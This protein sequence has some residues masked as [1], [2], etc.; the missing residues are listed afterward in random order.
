MLLVRQ[1][2]QQAE[3]AEASEAS[4]GFGRCFSEH[5]GGRGT[6]WREV[7]LRC[8]PHLGEPAPLPDSAGPSRLS[9]HLQREMT[10]RFE[11][12]HCSIYSTFVFS[13]EVIYISY[14]E[15]HEGQRSFATFKCNYERM[16]IPIQK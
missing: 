4:A 9:S 1:Q 15:K 10:S 16:L 7:F 3:S 8:S 2:V 5:N 6:A 13:E 11:R 12:L 14:L